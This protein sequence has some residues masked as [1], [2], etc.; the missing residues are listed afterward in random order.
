MS[1]ALNGD[2]QSMA[3]ACG[4]VE[5]ASRGWSPGID[6]DPYD[7]EEMEVM[8]LVWRNE[9]YDRIRQLETEN[10]HLERENTRLRDEM[11]D[12]KPPF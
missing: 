12:L 2:Y 11:E 3:E 7:A 8:R 6:F 5:Y 1:Y 9:R 10:A 4:E